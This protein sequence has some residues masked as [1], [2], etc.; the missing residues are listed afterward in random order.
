MFVPATKVVETGIKSIRYLLNSAV[1]HAGPQLKSI[2]FV[3]SMAATAAT[4]ALDGV[5]KAFDEEGWNE[6]SPAAF[7]EKG[8]AVD[9]ATAYRTGKTLAEREFWKFHAEKKRP[10][11]MTAMLPV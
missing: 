8:D 3:S 5:N 9:A 6:A 4:V 10:F 7:A 2:V 1:Q 11:S